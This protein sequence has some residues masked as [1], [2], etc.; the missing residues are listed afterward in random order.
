MSEQPSPPTWAVEFYTDARD[1]SP[2]GEFLDALP[3]P[4]R[5]EARNALRLLRE[6]GTL[7]GMPHARPLSGHR[8][9]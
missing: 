6:F 1:R 3:E 9:L 2:V 8:K 5:V 7:L 4:E